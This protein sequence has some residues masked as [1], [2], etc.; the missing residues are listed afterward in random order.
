ML[1][2]TSEQ[3]QS[4]LNR[5][6]TPPCPCVV[7]LG[8]SWISALR[9]LMKN[10]HLSPDLH[11]A[12]L[13][14]NGLKPKR[15]LMLRSS[16]ALWPLRRPFRASRNI[17]EAPECPLEKGKA[18]ALLTSDYLLKINSWMYIFLI[19]KTF[20]RLLIQIPRSLHQRGS[21]QFSPRTVEH[22]PPH[23]SPGQ[24]RKLS[25]TFEFSKLISKTYF[26]IILFW[27]S[28]L[29]RRWKV[30]KI[31]FIGHNISPFVVCLFSTDALI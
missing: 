8:W 25:F 16:K 21:Y 20:L 18:I 27:I 15:W 6:A 1:W 22:L 24:H 7:F 23:S 9:G 14:K 5:L 31:R 26:S 4:D 29:L 3:T 13:L 12:G 2:P 17:L 10:P 19:Q 11:C 28:L 30:F